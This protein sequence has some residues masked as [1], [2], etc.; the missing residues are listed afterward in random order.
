MK[1]KPTILLGLFLPMVTLTAAK[2]KNPGHL[3]MGL[4]NIKCIYS[5]TP[6]PSANQAAI[7][8]NLDRHLYFIDKL[9]A[10]GVE[11]IG[12]PEAS[13]NGYRWSADMTWLSPDG[14]EVGI[15]KKKAAEKGVYIAAGIAEQDTDGKRWENHFVI[16][17]DGKIAG[18]HRKNWLTKEKGFIEASRDHNV[19]EVKGAKMG[20]VICA[21]GT[22]FRNLKRGNRGQ[23]FIISLRIASSAFRSSLSLSALMRIFR[24][25]RHDNRGGFRRDKM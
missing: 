11:F 13:V 3:K 9:A 16:G 4:V 14:P 24:V 10:E 19:F 20:I 7:Q 18:F 22:D 21:D 2:D 15:L 5:D 12:F 23:S 8:T 25:A 1:F 17:P 6:D